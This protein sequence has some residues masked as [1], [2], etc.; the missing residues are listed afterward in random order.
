MGRIYKEY[1]TYL[2]TPTAQAKEEFSH[3]NSYL[4]DMVIFGRVSHTLVGWVDLCGL[5]LPPHALGWVG[6]S[7]WS[8]GGLSDVSRELHSVGWADESRSE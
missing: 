1:I 4:L 6:G 3:A 7:L 5:N 2:I 8:V